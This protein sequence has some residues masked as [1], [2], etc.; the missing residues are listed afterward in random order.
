MLQLNL[1]SK[2]TCW[3]Y[4]FQNTTSSW[5]EPL[6]MAMDVGHGYDTHVEHENFSQLEG[7]NRNEDKETKAYSLIHITEGMLFDCVDLC[8][9]EG[10]RTFILGTN[11]CGKS[12]LLKILAKRLSPKEGTIHHAHGLN[13]GYFDQ[14]IADDLI[15]NATEHMRADNKNTHKIITPLSYLKSLFPLKSEQDLR[16]QLS[17]FGLHGNQVNTNMR[18]LSGGERCRL[19]FS[20]LM[21]KSPHVL[22]FDEP[23]NHLDAESVNALIYGIQNWNGTAV[24]VSHDTNF[25]RM[26]EGDCF[27]LVENEGKLKRIPNGIDFYLKNFF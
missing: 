18:Y 12:T 13:I 27:L 26:V 23:T 24:I 11:G 16:G 8:I 5:G 10:T 4:S 17:S 3:K 20:I 15:Q 9:N 2:L 22:I 25:I 19:C 14:H 6:I 1:F 7:G 21:L